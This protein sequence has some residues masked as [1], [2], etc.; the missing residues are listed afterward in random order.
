MFSLLDETQKREKTKEEEEEE[1]E[2]KSYK[3]EPWQRIDVGRPG[4]AFQLFLPSRKF[5]ITSS[6]RVSLSFSFLSVSHRLE[7]DR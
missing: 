1:K 4:L 6:S 2:K 3:T 5:D 7:D